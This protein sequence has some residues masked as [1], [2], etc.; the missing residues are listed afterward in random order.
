MAMGL[1]PTS[2]SHTANWLK[3]NYHDLRLGNFLFAFIFLLSSISMVQDHPALFPQQKRRRKRERQPGRRASGRAK[4][5]VFK[6]L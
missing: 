3:T 5:F 6:R 4:V 1:S 2:R